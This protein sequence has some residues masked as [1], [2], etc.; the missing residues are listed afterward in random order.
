[1]T[2]SY[3]TPHVCKV[4]GCA[5]VTDKRLAD[6][7][8]DQNMIEC[9]WVIGSWLSA[10]C[11]DSRGPPPHTSGWSLSGEHQADGQ[12]PPLVDGPAPLPAEGH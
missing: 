4:Q 10:A 1:M 12:L 8:S 9:M 5:W 2:D 6:V 11:F 7:Q 3:F